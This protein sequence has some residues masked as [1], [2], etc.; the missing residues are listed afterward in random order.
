MT[1]V[2]SRQQKKVART[3]NTQMLHLTSTRDKAPERGVAV[4]EVPKLPP[5]TLDDLDENDSD[6]EHEFASFQLKLLTLWMSEPK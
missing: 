4:G 5:V 2:P 3:K 1:N 6:E